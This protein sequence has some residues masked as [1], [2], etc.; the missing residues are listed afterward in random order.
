MTLQKKTSQ[1]LKSVLFSSYHQNI[2]TSTSPWLMLS[3]IHRCGYISPLLKCIKL[4]AH[5]KINTNVCPLFQP[6]KSFKVVISSL[7]LAPKLAIYELLRMPWIQQM[8]TIWILTFIYNTL[9]YLD[10][11]TQIHLKLNTHLTSPYHHGI[12]YYYLSYTLLTV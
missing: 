4:L 3:G 2:V 1:S 12:P 8:S 10:I 9:C 7:S 5:F 11:W 6:T